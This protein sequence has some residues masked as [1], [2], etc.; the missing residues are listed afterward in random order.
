MGIE[1]G[2]CCDE[3]LVMCVSD[4]SR[5]STLEAKTTLNVR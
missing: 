1:E 2:T 5:E 4:E 3:H